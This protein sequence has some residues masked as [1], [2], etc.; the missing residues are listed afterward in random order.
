MRVLSMAGGLSR[1]APYSVLNTSGGHGGSFLA[2]GLCLI[3]YKM[4]HPPYDN[5]SAPPL[6]L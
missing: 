5:E 6:I 4:L 1:G 3:A 2:M